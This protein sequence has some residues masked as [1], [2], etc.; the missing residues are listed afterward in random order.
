VLVNRYEKGGTVG[1]D[2]LRKSLG[3]VAFRTV[4]NSY[5]D[6]NSSIDQGTALASV[7][8]SSSVAKMLG[9]LADSLNPKQAPS[10]SLL[11]RLF[12]RA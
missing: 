3:K 8:R 7:A 5:K 10:R 11:G 1:T 2:D 6:V 9:E 12:K 4:P